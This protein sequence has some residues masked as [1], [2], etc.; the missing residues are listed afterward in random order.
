MISIDATPI[1]WATDWATAWALLSPERY[2]IFVSGS[3]V[4]PFVGVPMVKPLPCKAVDS[5]PATPLACDELA[6]C[7]LAP[8]VV[9]VNAAVVVGPEASGGIVVV[10]DGSIVVAT[11][12][13]EEAVPPPLSSLRMFF[14]IRKPTTTAAI[15][16][17]IANVEPIGDAPLPE[18][19]GGRLGCSLL[20]HAPS[21]VRASHHWPR[22]Q[23]SHDDV[24]RDDDADGAPSTGRTPKLRARR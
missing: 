7:T 15:A 16:M 21:D 19:F 6:T 23:S 22:P 17:T 8:W 13:V 1:S 2:W 3:F 9:G 14:R 18:R 4:A 10:C 12:V 11:G 20:M 24:A 5:T